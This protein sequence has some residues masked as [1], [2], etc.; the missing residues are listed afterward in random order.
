MKNIKLNVCG[1]E[2]I[3]EFQ[4]KT[5]FVVK[6]RPLNKPLDSIGD[7]LAVQNTINNY[8]IAEGFLPDFEEIV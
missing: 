6:W 8:L 3:V 5:N 2:V 7:K 4:S 1:C